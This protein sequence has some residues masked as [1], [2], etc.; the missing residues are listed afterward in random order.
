MPGSLV[1]SRRPL[2]TKMGP[3]YWVWRTLIARQSWAISKGSHSAASGKASSFLR[4]SGCTVIRMTGARG[5]FSL[6]KRDNA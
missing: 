4:S 3:D 1:W 6:I 2:G 5:L